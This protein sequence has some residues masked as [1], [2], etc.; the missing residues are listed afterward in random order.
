MTET[1]NHKTHDSVQSQKNAVIAVYNT[2]EEAEDA[3]K[4]LEAQG[5][6]MVHLSIV[7]RNY[8]TERDKGQLNTE[9]TEEHEATQR[10][11]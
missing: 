7:G 10:K 1:L 6:D 9:K 4:Q 8:H 3:V 2:H 11:N 5:F